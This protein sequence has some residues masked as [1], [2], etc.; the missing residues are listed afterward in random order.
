LR[1]AV[2]A[3]LEITAGKRR[4]HVLERFSFGVDTD[5]GFDDSAENHQGGA[6]EIADQQGRLRAGADDPAEEDRRPYSAGQGS[7]GVEDRDSESTN[8]ERENFGDGE[9]SGAPQRGLTEKNEPLK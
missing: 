5:E 6:D 2:E 3:P 9:I 7:E 8:L 4:C 1:R